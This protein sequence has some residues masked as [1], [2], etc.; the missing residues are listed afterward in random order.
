MKR[1]GI[2][3]G[4]SSL[5]WAI[6]DDERLQEGQV[7]GEHAPSLI[8][9]GV[10]VF[11]EGMERDK[12]DNLVSPAAERRQKRAARR[13]IFRRKLRKFQM[14]QALSELGMCPIKSESLHLWRTKGVYPIRDEAFMAWLSATPKH[15]PYVDRKAAAEGPV[16]PLVLG[17]ALYHIAQ[18]RGFKSSRKEQ[19]DALTVEEDG[20]NKSSRKKK[21]DELTQT[22]QAID[23]LSARL[24]GRTLGQYFY[25]CYEQGIKIRKQKTGRVEHYEKEFDVIARVQNLA[26]DVAKRL[27]TILFFQ[28]PLKIQ[29]HL[30]GKCL[31]EK[32]V[33]YLFRNP[34]TDVLERRERVRYPRCLVSHPDFERYRALCFLN[35]LRVSEQKPEDGRE[36]L[37]REDE[38]R[39]LTSEER[40]KVL[41]NL[42]RKSRATIGQVLPKELYS[43]YRPTDDA[44]IMPTT[45][46]FTLLNL[47]PEQ[48][49]KAFNALVD[50]DDLERLRDWSMRHFGFDEKQAH[51]FICTAVETARASYSLH[52]IRKILPYLERGMKVRKATFCARLCDVV[53]NFDAVKSEL[54]KDLSACDEEYEREKEARKQNPKQKIRPLELDRY[55]T[56]LARKYCVDNKAFGQLYI[57][58]SETNT[59]DPVLPC[60]NLE[61]IRN[62]LARRALTVLRRLVNTLRREGKID[63]DTRITIELAHTV[64]A[65]N[66]CRAIEKYQLE[67]RDLRERARNDLQVHIQ[68]QGLNLAITDELILRYLLWEEQGKCCI[69]TG[70]S[71]GIGQMLSDT[72]IEHTIPRSRGGT[73]KMENLTLCH[74]HYNRNIKRNLLPSECPNAKVPYVDP[75]NGKT[76]DPITTMKVLKDWEKQLAALEKELTKRPRRG[77]DPAA[78]A[79]TRQAYLVKQMKRNYLAAKLKTFKLTADDVDNASFIPRQMV[80][81]GIITKYAVRFLKTRYPH[82]KTVNGAATAFARK[83]WGLQREGEA[84]AR[85][86]HTHHAVDAMVIAALDEG[87]FQ[88]ICIALGRE[89]ACDYRAVCPPPYP[90]FGE[91]IQHACNTILVRHLPLNRHCHPFSYVGK[92]PTRKLAGIRGSLHNDTLYGRI[93]YQGETKTVLRKT[94]FGLTGKDFKALAESAV[95]KAIREKLSAQKAAYEDAGIAPNDLSKQAYWM[96]EPSEGVRGVPILSVRAFVPKPKNPDT[97]REQQFNPQDDVYGSGGDLVEL[98][99]A[100]T[101]KGKPQATAISLLDVARGLQAVTPSDTGASIMRLRP[102]MHALIY[103]ETPQELKALAPDELQKRLYVLRKFEESGRLTLWFHREARKATVLSKELKANGKNADGESKLGFR[104]PERLLLLSM[105]TYL[106]HMLFEG[107][108][109]VFTLDGR[110]EWL[111]C[112]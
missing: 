21:D 61:A 3:L 37:R 46:T 26:P 67:R 38:S 77:G 83:A 66:T 12:S 62:P 81:T 79:A 56:L 47:P 15:N 10:V 1:L 98:R 108:H 22:K 16:D 9:C 14:L 41:D 43:N 74:S 11:P 90:H 109:F 45:A 5:G 42:K 91:C 34:K 94:I 59:V 36:R 63:A 28:R 30:V 19:L 102:G 103:E 89:E 27:R 20:A 93:Q 48:W 88:D 72:D 8:D 39:P 105:S 58:I 110:I 104:V 32:N 7:F 24:E 106:S 111:N 23:A 95:D 70:Q 29:R 97:I 31:I 99:I 84:K 49:Q 57:D 96:R 75:T 25:E 6:L 71:I 69:Y 64:N 18:R 82:I 60:V 54:L 2:D 112:D 68:A 92:S 17:R 40:V 78:F 73:S 51:R 107:I 85:I 53:P 87:R 76:Y 86:D 4:T 55:R 33:S 50:F 52:A 100:K 44:P 65:A 35:N 80:D 101:S 13:L